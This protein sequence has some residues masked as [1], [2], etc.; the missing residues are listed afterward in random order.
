VKKDV[1]RIASGGK[2]SPG[3]VRLSGERAALPVLEVQMIAHAL[4]SP[5]LA[6][7]VVFGLSSL[8]YAAPPRD[9][10]G[11]CRQD[12]DDRPTHCEVRELTVPAGGDI[13]VD[14]APNGGIEVTGWD[15]GEVR[16]LAKVTARAESEAEAQALASQVRIQ[17]NG[18]IRA[19]GPDTRSRRS[20]WVSYRLSVPQG[21][22]LSLNTVNGGISLRDVSGTVDLRT[23]NGGVDVDRAAGRITG[24]TQNG[25]LDVRLAGTEWDGEGLDLE[26]SNGGVEL[27]VPEGYNAELTTG[28]VNGGLDL[29]FPVTVQGRIKKR[30]EVTLGRGG[31]PIRAMT[32]NGG[33]SLRRR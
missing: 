29:D 31:A 15:R 33:I 25:G 23:V 17:T 27:V 12:G 8:A 11:W 28:T 13:A 6:V 4:R 20:W 19:E 5:G 9:G 32:T 22:R 10:S 26:T 21:V 2:P 3:F 30:I 16:V 14:A 24:R 18:T 7:A 1:T